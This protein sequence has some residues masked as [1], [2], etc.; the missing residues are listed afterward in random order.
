MLAR[1]HILRNGASLPVTPLGLGSAPLGDLFDKLDETVAHATVAGAFAAGIR[2]FDTSPHYG[3]GLAEARCGAALRT[4]PRDAITV[5]TKVGRVMDPF[6][7]PVA[8]A[9]DVASPGFAGGFPH[10]A[11]FDYSQDGVMRSVEQSLLRTGLGRFDILLIHD[12]DVWTQ[13]ADHID[14][15]FGEAMDGAYRALDRLRAEGTVGAIGVGVNEADMCERFARAGDFDVMMLAGRYSLLEQPALTRFLPLATEKNI[16]VLLAGIFNSGILATGPVPGARYNYA[17]AP[18][19][20][21]E[22]VAAIARICDRHGVPLRHAALQFATV[23]PAVLS[24][25]LGAVAPNEVNDAVAAI[26]APIPPALWS[27]LRSAGLL[28]AAAPTPA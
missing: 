15:V 20:V 2:V 11:R 21:L 22:R 14:R 3:N 6:A 19:A 24:V 8:Q 27:D 17:P 28:D 4:L 23:H 12:C 16:G 18:P 5:S 25:V 9:G 26:A 1:T 10:R 13:G 7:P